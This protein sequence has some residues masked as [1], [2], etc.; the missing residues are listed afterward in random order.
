MPYLQN[1]SFS[2]SFKSCQ[3]A[4]LEEKC[5]WSETA[6]EVQLDDVT[7]FRLSAM[8]RRGPNQE[9]FPVRASFGLSRT[10]HTPSIIAKIKRVAGM[11]DAMPAVHIER[12]FLI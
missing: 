2:K 7:T 6:I 12:K 8:R 11:S 5:P 10:P 1:H 9:T 3:D 4:T